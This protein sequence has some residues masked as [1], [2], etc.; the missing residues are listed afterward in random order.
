MV[1]KLIEYT[2]FF[3]EKEERGCSESRLFMST[4]RDQA[5][6]QT[7]ER[8][9]IWTTLSWSFCGNIFGVGVAQYIEKNSDKYYSLKNFRKR[10][11]LKVG[12]F[13]LTVIAFTLY[14][15]GNAQ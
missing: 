8:D 13:A 3:K 14:G 12:G 1:D 15:Y 9:K 4:F 2:F 11:L 6:Q 7:Q 10:E 5:V